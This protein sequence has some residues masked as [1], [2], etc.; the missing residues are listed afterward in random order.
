MSG[1][2]GFGAILRGSRL[3]QVSSAP[4]VQSN[5]PIYGSQKHHAPQRQVIATTPASRVRKD[6]GLKNVMP[7]GWNSPY[8]TLEHLDHNGMTKYDHGSSFYFKKRRFDEMG[9]A[10]V[11]NNSNVPS[12]F[13]KP[14]GNKQWSD[15]K[16]K[17]AKDIVKNAPARRQEF[18]KFVRETG[19]RATIKGEQNHDELISKFYG[20]TDNNSRLVQN[21]VVKGN[22][23]MSYLLQGSMNN[24]NYN[25]GTIY[26]RPVPGRVNTNVRYGSSVDTVSVGGF[27][28]H[29]PSTNGDSSKLAIETAKL[30]N[31]GE[32][33]IRARLHGDKRSALSSTIDAVYE[34]HTPSVVP[35]SISKKSQ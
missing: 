10:L 35:E 6:F 8:I 3:T 19:K 26:S 12:L 5:N 13:A 14:S 33:N 30:E 20:I 34:T 2:K 17:E 29:F 28:A 11:P 15:L 16:L 21:N 27:I 4:A 31:N 18:L 32:I 9:V 1:T 24:T 25:M 22:A 23:G 7:K